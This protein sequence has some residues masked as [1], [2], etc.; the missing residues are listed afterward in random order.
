MFSQRTVLIIGILALICINAAFLFY[1]LRHPE[2]SPG[3]SGLALPLAA[4][5]QEA[6][7]ALR[8]KI[9]DCWQDYFALVSVAQENRSL[10][11]ALRQEQNR[12]TR[13]TEMELAN[14]RLR[15]LLSLRRSMD[16]PVLAAEVTARDPSPWH[17][18]LTVNR[19]STDGLRKGQ[20]VT[21][22]EGTVG[23]ISHVSAHYARVLLLSDP[24]SAVDV[25]IQRTRARGIVRGE[26][27]GLCTCEYILRREEVREGDILI[28]SGLDGLFPKGQ[29][30]GQ[31]S[32]IMPVSSGIFQKIM[33]TPFADFEKIEEV[34]ILMQPE[35]RP[36]ETEKGDSP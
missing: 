33:V 7:D 2:L 3:T 35:A 36:P 17:R 9:R 22:P 15:E 20:P 10:R 18:S 12:H 5:L 24:N 8:R 14:T 6:A 27:A 28:T 25:L 26:S 19:G 32:Q 21:V 29:R 34:L 1:A 31:V 11:T 30:V 13:C 23:V 4:P 16:L